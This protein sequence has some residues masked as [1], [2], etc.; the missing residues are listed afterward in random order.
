MFPEIQLISGKPISTTL[1]IPTFEGER[2]E[3]WLDSKYSESLEFAKQEG[4]ESKLSQ[5]HCSS[6]IQEGRQNTVLFVGLG[7]K[8]KL[9]SENFRRALSLVAKKLNSLK[10]STFDVVLPSIVLSCKEDIKEQILSICEG[11]LLSSY[12]F[13]KY[14]SDAKPC[15]IKNI[16]LV[17]QSGLNTDIKNIV[18][19][20]VQLA[21]TLC[22]STCL[23]R[24]LVNLAPSDLNPVRFVHH[25]QSL[26]HDSNIDIDI[27]EKED[28]EKKKMGALLGVGRGSHHPPY[29]I[30]L[31]YKSKR[32]NPKK[33][34]A[35]VGKGITFDSGGLSLKPPRYMETMKMDM[36]GAGTVVGIFEGLKHLDLD[37]DVHGI[38]AIS[39]NLPGYDA[40]KPGD[41]L[42]A[43]N[44]KTIEV[45]NTDAEGRLVLADAL[46]YAGEKGVDII[47]D[48]A[49]LTGACVVALGEMVT[50]IIGNDQSLVCEI[51]K[52]GKLSGERYCEL[53]LV[54][55]YK[56]RMQSDIADLRNIS[57]VPSAGTIM[58][59]IFLENF[60]PKNVKWAHLDI[61]GTAWQDKPS[62]YTQ[63]GGTGTCVRTLIHYLMNQ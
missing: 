57:T 42:T 16:H 8:I 49:T 14:K 37:V 47:F 20:D 11:L 33:S 22:Q 58:G 43:M 41:I 17:S 1:V 10:K 34:I 21:A 38:L 28:L 30:H 52:S 46:T 61:A 56:K 15:C 60:V 12:T 35:L 39:D 59:A 5:I 62:E 45:L 25:V 53:P 9:Q 50:A 44:G 40:V 4:F 23:T 18:D 31:H 24:D 3:E 19:Y 2:L 26:F 13:D 6:Y 51:Q 48:F 55:D 54:E 27:F 32:S 29:M 7:D 36:A 63:S